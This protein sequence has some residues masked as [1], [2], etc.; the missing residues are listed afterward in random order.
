MKT[1][2]LVFVVVVG[3]LA[4]VGVCVAFAPLLEKR[5]ERAA[6]RD[7]LKAENNAME[8]RIGDLRR[9]QAEFESNPEF[10]ELQAHNEGMVRSTE[11]VFDFSEVLPK[12]DMHGD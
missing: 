1:L 5:T 7:R 4:V 10:V 11:R 8:R 12:D 2:R 6:E 3:A 9:R